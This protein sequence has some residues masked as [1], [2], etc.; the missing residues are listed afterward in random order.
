MCTNVHC[1]QNYDVHLLVLY[2]AQRYIFLD[3]SL[4]WSHVRNSHVHKCSQRYIFLD[5]SLIWSKF[6]C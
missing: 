1:T 6:S 3:T 4:I 2:K 5:T